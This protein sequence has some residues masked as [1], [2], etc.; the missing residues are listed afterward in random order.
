MDILLVVF[1]G[2]LAIFTAGLFYVTSRSLK[3]QGEYYKAISRPF[4]SIVV[5]SINLEREIH[6]H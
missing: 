6:F 5:D 1:T 3:K 4:V 2:A